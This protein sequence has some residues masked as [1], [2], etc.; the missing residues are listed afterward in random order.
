MASQLFK[1]ARVHWFDHKDMLV[2]LNSGTAADKLI[3]H[4]DMLRV[5]GPR[6]FTDCDFC[7]AQEWYT[8]VTGVNQFVMHKCIQPDKLTYMQSRCSTVLAPEWCHMKRN[9]NIALGTVA[10]SPGSRCLFVSA[11][12]EK[13]MQ[14][15]ASDG[16][17]IWRKRMSP[18][19]TTFC[20][21]STFAQYNLHD[22]DFIILTVNG[23]TPI[24][25]QEGNPPIFLYAHDHHHPKILER[26]PLLLAQ[27]PMA[28]FTPY[29]TIWAKYFDIPKTTKV[30]FTPYFSDTLWATMNTDFENR[31]L[32]VLI[33]GTT[34]HAYQ[35]RA[36]IHK[37]MKDKKLPFKFQIWNA[38]APCIQTEAISATGYGPP[39]MNMWFQFLSKARI[40]V[41]G[42]DNWGYLVNKYAEIL[43]ACSLMVA[44]DLPDCRRGGL[45]ANHHFIP[46]SRP[47]TTQLI[48]Q[49][50]EL[51][52]CFNKYAPIALNGFRWFR[53]KM[54]TYEYTEFWNA[55]DG[56]L[57]GCI[58]E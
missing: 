42:Q 51:S 25:P 18:Y 39:V 53:D 49:L 9:Y 46:I 32:D 38:A 35:E 33:L 2:Q 58:N 15:G 29:P 4:A 3:T 12:P 28:I 31:P 45:I 23:L 41:F 34:G 55:V 27:N 6:E 7:A 30:I 56:M 14:H 50:I 8:R 37:L 40:C 52:A 22:F 54:E 17:M 26:V 48:P 19:Q 11:E 1:T 36:A 44:P 5:G 24:I 43:G 20:D 57:Q 47:V 21:M 16:A 10:G 13:L